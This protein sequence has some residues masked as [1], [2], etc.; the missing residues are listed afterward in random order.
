MLPRV[1]RRRAAAAVLGLLASVATGSCSAG[2]GGDEATSTACTASAPGVSPGQLKL[3]MIIPDTGQLSGPFTTARAGIEGRVGLVNAAGGVHGRRILLDW[4]D[5]GSSNAK[6]LTAARDLVDN[7]GVF[8]L[9]EATA[10]AS[11]SADYLASQSVPVTGIAAEPV[12][13][14]HANMFTFA[15]PYAS[16]PSVSTFGQ[17]ADRAGGTRAVVLRNNPSPSAEIVAGKLTASLTSQNIPVVATIDY[18]E[19]ISSP[20]QVAATILGTGA[21]VVAGAIAGD[22]LATVLQALRAAGGSPKAV[23]GPD[24]HDPRMIAKY[25]QAVAGMSVYT[26]ITPFELPSAA[27]DTY[28]SAVTTYAPESDGAEQ[29]TTLQAYIATDMFLR[30]LEVAGPCPTRSGFVTALRNVSDYDAGGLLPGPVDLHSAGARLSSCYY[31]VQVNAAGSGFEVV[32]G[33]AGKDRL[34]WCGEQL[35]G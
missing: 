23:F 3:G 26:P 32:S 19:G 11:G 28:R 7:S 34:Q 16:G 18:T 21:D 13:G 24:G 10:A 31:F 22:S 15:F 5:D 1:L 35:A 33:G 2:G 20:R 6:N 27:M 9:I 4:R 29:I 17:Y 30:G 12:W 25:G 8:G 14:T